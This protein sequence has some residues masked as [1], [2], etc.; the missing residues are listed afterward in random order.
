MP[1]KVSII[2]GATLG[3]GRAAAHMLAAP[4]ETLILVG[5]NERAGGKISR[6]LRSRNPRAIIEYIRA[7]L[8][9]RSDVVSLATTIRKS[10]DHVDVLI[11]N[12]G[13]RIDD[14]RENG[15]GIE[16]TFATNHLGHF[17]LTNLL[18]KHLLRAPSARI[19]TVGS[20]SH[21]G[22][23]AQGDW[24]LNR[25]NYDRRVAYGNSK[26][27]NI[28]FSYE[29]AERLR[30]TR[31]TSNAVDPGGVASHF[32]SN[33][34]WISW[35]RHLVAHGIKRQLVLPRKG[36]ETL[37]YLARSSEVEGVTG[38]YFFRNRETQSSTASHDRQEGRRLWDL[39]IEL[40]GLTRHAGSVAESLD[41]C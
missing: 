35:L 12:A 2:T 32:A 7:D 36:A 41:A 25:A 10:H 5:R 22:A 1:E 18:L 9:V 28:M 27:A 33:N 26:L 8:S 6:Q 37:V 40:S 3:I 11:N 39:S 38:K 15:D 31:A 30:N 4:D 34:G 14:Y 19:I 24:V 13:A 21:F 16:L 23:S 20:G 17:L 29:L